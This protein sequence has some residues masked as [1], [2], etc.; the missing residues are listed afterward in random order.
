MKTIVEPK[1][2]IVRLWGKQS[3]QDQTIYRLMKYLLRY[4]SEDGVLLH[5]VITGH[6]VLLTENEGK[7]LE[8]LPAK[9]SSVMKEMIENQDKLNK[10]S[11][12]TTLI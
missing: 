3:I 11:K 1:E 6:I 2:Y 5:N 10:N 9:A 4:D 7:A 8:A 12:S